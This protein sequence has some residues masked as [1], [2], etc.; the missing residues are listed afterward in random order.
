MISFLGRI[1]HL[2]DGSGLHEIFFGISCGFACKNCKGTT[3]RD[4][5]VD[6]PNLKKFM[7]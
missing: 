7:Y 1:G 3:C 2:M 6:D 4:A 5:E